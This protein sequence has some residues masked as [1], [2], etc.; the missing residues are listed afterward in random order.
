M[1]TAIVQYQIPFRTGLQQV[2]MSIAGTIRSV[3]L[4]GDVLLVFVEAE[5]APERT[6]LRDIH[7]IINEMVPDGLI[8]LNTLPSDQ[9][10]AHVYTNQQP[11]AETI[12]AAKGE[13]LAH[14][15]DIMALGAEIRYLRGLVDR[16]T[17]NAAAA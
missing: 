2:E 3:G 13:P 16:L 8:Y 14:Y 1:A 12:E 7:V 17:L 9:G 6:V 10:F 11:T 5:G 4:M 15:T